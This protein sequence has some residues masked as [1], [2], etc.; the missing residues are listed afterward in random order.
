MK[1][2]FKKGQLIRGIELAYYSVVVL[3]LL[4]VAILIVGLTLPFIF[5]SLHYAVD[6]GDPLEFRRYLILLALTLAGTIIVIVVSGRFLVQFTQ[7]MQV[8]IN[9]TRARH[10]VAHED[11]FATKP[12]VKPTTMPLFAE[13]HDCTLYKVCRSSNAAYERMLEQAGLTEAIDAFRYDQS[14]LAK[15][16]QGIKTTNCKEAAELDDCIIQ[17]AL[18][19]GYQLGQTE[20]I[21]IGFRRGARRTE[22]RIRAELDD[23]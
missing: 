16:C 11:N 13:C 20:G 7:E 4:G 9:G 3:C 2:N 6:S 18:E 17:T 14:H 8:L 21:A 12:P 10:P 15:I 19:Y 23:N 5:S 22:T 1:K